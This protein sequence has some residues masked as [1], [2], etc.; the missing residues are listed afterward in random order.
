MHAL[1]DVCGKCVA[2]RLQRAWQWEN[3]IQYFQEDEE[4]RCGV[5]VYL[6]RLYDVGGCVGEFFQKDEELRCGVRVCICCVY[7]YGVGG[8][9]SSDY[10]GASGMSVCLLV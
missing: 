3:R 6:L 4:L 7:L 1:A 2:R 10:G 9:V 5:C 8:W